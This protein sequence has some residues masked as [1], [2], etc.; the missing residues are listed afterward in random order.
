[1]LLNH[2][3]FAECAV[4]M[5]ARVHDHSEADD[6]RL[7]F[8]FQLCLTRPPAEPEMQALSEL[9]AAR[10]AALRSSPQKAKEILSATITV[11]EGDPVELAAWAGVT[12]A[13]L[14]LDEC[15]NRE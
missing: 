10:R 12:R 9:L 4:A 8:A 7:R 3:W 2:P 14:N 6:D 11:Q 15:I 1:M 13:I 5:A